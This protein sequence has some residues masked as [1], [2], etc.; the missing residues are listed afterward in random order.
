[1][2]SLSTEPQGKPKNV[3]VGNIPFPVDLPILGMEPRSPALQEDSLPTELSRRPD[4][5]TK[6]AVKHAF[7]NGFLCAYMGEF[8]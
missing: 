7:L 6:S 3:A 8:P 5:I 2:D 4:S 1:M